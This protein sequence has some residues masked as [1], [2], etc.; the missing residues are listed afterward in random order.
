MRVSFA[1]AAALG[2]TPGNG[3]INGINRVEVYDEEGNRLFFKDGAAAP[4]LPKPKLDAIYFTGE[5]LTDAVAASACPYQVWVDSDTGPA[6]AGSGSLLPP[7]RYGSKPVSGMVAL[8]N[9][10]HPY[11]AGA[12]VKLTAPQI[13]AIAAQ[14]P[15]LEKALSDVMSGALDPTKLWET[16]E[17]R[18]PPGDMSFVLH[19]MGYTVDGK[20]PM[21][22]SIEYRTWY[23][24]RWGRQAPAP[25]PR[26]PEAAWLTDA[27][28]AAIIAS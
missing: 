28:L 18:L 5:A 9:P 7:I 15:T 26:N 21:Q 20:S 17:S 10:D 19:W 12:E 6:L 13:G 16:V 1:I 22:Q 25:A 14:A 11:F 3:T 4:P 27:E 24:K 23:Y 2:M 8:M